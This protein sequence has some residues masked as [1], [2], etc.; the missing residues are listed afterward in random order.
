MKIY[1]N[2]KKGKVYLNYQVST[3]SELA[4]LI[5][6]PWFNLNGKQ[7]HVHQVLA[8]SPAVSTTAGAIVGGIIGLLG[9]PVGVLIGGALGGA[10]GNEGDKSEMFKA[11]Y[12]NQSK[13]Q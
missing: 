2:D 9:G 12:F 5:G 8:E 7:Y 13:V 4:R 11:N 1:V 10:I 6:S 3:R